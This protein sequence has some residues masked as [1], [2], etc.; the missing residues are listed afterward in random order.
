MVNGMDT[1]QN[2]I[3]IA[4]GGLWAVFAV[5]LVRMLRQR[6]SSPRYGLTRH[7][8]LGIIVLFEV[9]FV[10]SAVFLMLKQGFSVEAA[11][12]TALL[13]NQSFDTMILRFGFAVSYV[14]TLFGAIVVV[15]SKEAVKQSFRDSDGT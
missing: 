12:S 13:I 1:A 7:H 2:W 14:L 4:L 6:S 11:L 8:R 15:R 3:V 9:C 5:I 10:A